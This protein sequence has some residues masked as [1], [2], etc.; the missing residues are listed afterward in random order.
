LN[1]VLL[2]SLVDDSFSFAYI[3]V[4]T[5]VLLPAYQALPANQPHSHVVLGSFPK[6]KKVATK[7]IG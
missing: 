5:Q 3:L 4:Y 2:A 7:D 1:S 6:Q